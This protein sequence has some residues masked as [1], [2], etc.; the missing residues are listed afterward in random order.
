MKPGATVV[1][2]HTRRQLESVGWK[3]GDPIPGDL[4][5]RLQQAQQM[6]TADVPLQDLPIA[7]GWKPVNTSF[8]DITSLP[9]EKQ[10]EIAD[11]L[12]AYKKETEQAAVAAEARA[13]AEKDLPP[14]ISGADREAVL[15]QM[16]LSDQMAN[17]RSQQSYV[18]DDRVSD[19]SAAA[20]PVELPTGVVDEPPSAAATAPPVHICKR[21]NWPSDIPF[22]VKPTDD[23]KRVF[24]I[25]MLGNTRF[26][27]AYQLL[28]GM[29]AA[30]FR[31]L[32]SRE[33]MLLHAHLGEM[34]RS[35]QSAG[36]VEYIANM[37]EF[38]LVMSL[39][40]IVTAA[41]VMY[42]AP[43]VFTWAKD[44]K[45]EVD[46]LPRFRDYMYE[47]VVNEPVR[48]VIGE[49]H[50]AFQRLVGLL[51]TQASSEDFWKGIELQP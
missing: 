1:S 11:Y 14:G 19:V 48:I 37:A 9:A 27:K 51:E 2:E 39:E 31:S 41:G 32:S 29:M 47:K 23:D 26:R 13:A 33:T 49:T 34:V 28:G 38:R 21:C 7:A 16:Q 46:I 40:S 45:V 20:S 50:Q 15:R 6:L 24:L 10:K 35:S 3:V 25:A 5:E 22:E 43:D 18:I 12:A 42:E 36:Q 4:G 8:V 17:E 44:N 30:T